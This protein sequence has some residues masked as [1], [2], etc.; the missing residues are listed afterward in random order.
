[1]LYIRKNGR[2]YEETLRSRGKEEEQ[3]SRIC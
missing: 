2:N 3:K 1:L